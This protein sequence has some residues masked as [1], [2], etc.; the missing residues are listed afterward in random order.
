MPFATGYTKAAWRA[1][2]SGLPVVIRRPRSQDTDNVASFER[3]ATMELAFYQKLKSSPRFQ[4]LG[5]KVA[6]LYGSCVQHGPPFIVTEGN[7]R[8][9]YRP[10]L[11]RAIDL[12]LQIAQLGLSMERAG[13]VHC[14]WKLEQLAFTRSGDVRVVDLEGFRDINTSA[15]PCSSNADCG[16]VCRPVWRRGP[17]R[18][19]QMANLQEN[20]CLLSS[21][22]CHGSV[23]TTPAMVWMTADTVYSKLFFGPVNRSKIM[24]ELLSGM[25]SVDAGARWTWPQ[26]IEH[27]RNESSRSQQKV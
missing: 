4:T 15:V 19:Y 14:D 21:R 16:K 10:S 7:L 22:R 24:V 27:L 11:Q 5:P 6:R 9:E 23:R 13:V 1:N 17:E 26:V 18:Q 25:Q 8:K 12:A 20:Q 3:L 2:W